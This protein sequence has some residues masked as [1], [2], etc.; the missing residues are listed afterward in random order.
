MQSNEAPG[1]TSL[2]P[3]E[4]EITIQDLLRHTSG[5]TYGMHRLTNLDA[6]HRAYR[7]AEVGCDLDESRRIIAE[8]GRERD[9]LED[10]AGGQAAAR[11]RAGP[12]AR[13]R[14][15]VGARRGRPDDR[16]VGAVGR[17]RHRLADVAERAG[18]EAVGP[19]R[20]A[21]TR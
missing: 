18:G 20:L 2:V 14:E 16:E 11:A 5:L 7:L 6:A 21:A 13:H 10:R 1:Q 17:R 12:R 15:H 8:L 4:R 3:A 9:V 19:A